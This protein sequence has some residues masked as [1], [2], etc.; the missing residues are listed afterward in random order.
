MDSGTTS[1]WATA[2]Q[3]TQVIISGIYITGRLGTDALNTMGAGVYRHRRRWRP[4]HRRRGNRRGDYSSMTLDPIDQ[5][6]FYYTNE[7]L[8]TNGAFNWS[9]R[10]ATYRFPSCANATAWGTVTGTITSTETGAPIPG[11]TVTLSNG[12]A[13]AS[14]AN[15]VYTIVVPAGSYTATAADPDRNC[16]T[17]TPGSANVAPQ[18]G[19]IVTQN[20]AM[21]GTSKLEA[22][23]V[24]IDDSLGNSNGV[25]N[26]AECIKLNVGLKNNGCAKETAIS[27]TLS[28]TTPG[29][30]VLDGASAYPNMLIDGTGANSTPFR[31]STSSSFVCGTDIS[32]S[33]NL[34]YA[35][36][37]K[38]ISLILPSCAGG[39]NQSIPPYSLTTS[40]LT[41]GDRLGRDG[42]PSTC[43][44]KLSPGGGFAGLNI[45]RPG[46]STITV[47]VR[48][49]SLS[50]LTPLLAVR[51]T[52]KVPHT[53]KATIRRI[54][55][56]I[57]WATAA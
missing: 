45:T 43:S 47:A 23:G 33:L 29:V 31:I 21:T 24:T 14:D 30:T 9:T 11:V 12:Y 54:S 48:A 3:I 53:I 55:A 7:Y 50:R 17:A 52:S 46:P 4:D 18:S 1:R 38:T 41:Q 20:F 25:I 6:T 49:A 28:T 16:A 19:G 26:K 34:T 13:S 35:S 15:G 57:I 22:N 10:I 37:T 36:G 8:K 32:L 2:N 5:C 56:P 42:F 40:D 27:A 39:A 44:G 51:G